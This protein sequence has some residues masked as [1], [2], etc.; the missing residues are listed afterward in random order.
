L[1]KVAGK[2]ASIMLVLTKYVGRILE[3]ERNTIRE[4]DIGIP[5]VA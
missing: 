2:R 4:R 3:S 1:L 5:I